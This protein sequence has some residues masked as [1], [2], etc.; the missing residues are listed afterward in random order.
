[1]REGI[2]RKMWSYK[3]SMD[4]LKN[5]TVSASMVLGEEREGLESLNKIFH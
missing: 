2:K 4:T 3:I 1:M 5:S